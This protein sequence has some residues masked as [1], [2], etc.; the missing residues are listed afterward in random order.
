M[1]NNLGSQFSHIK[2]K[3][4]IYSCASLWTAQFPA[5]ARDLGDSL[6]PMTSSANPPN[7][8]RDL[9]FREVSDLNVQCPLTPFQEGHF[10]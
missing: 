4:Q 1:K 8:L 10:K 6:H 7:L 3:L 9:D 2:S 5:R